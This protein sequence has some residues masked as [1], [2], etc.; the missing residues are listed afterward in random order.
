MEYHY[1]DKE[2]LILCGA[3]DATIITGAGDRRSCC[4]RVGE[5]EKAISRFDIRASAL[6]GTEQGARGQEQD[7]LGGGPAVAGLWLPF[8]TPDAL[9]MI[10][11]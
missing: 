9:G 5:E 11:L 8:S 6:P 4:Q 7:L 10:W 1:P 3:S 2:S